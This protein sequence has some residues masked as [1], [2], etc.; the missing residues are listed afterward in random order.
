[1]IFLATFPINAL[2]PNFM[3]ILLVT[4]E[5]FYADGQTDIKKLIAVFCNFAKAPNKYIFEDDKLSSFRVAK[6]HFYP[7]HAPVYE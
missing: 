3:K 4:A 6:S 2:I 1:M 7:T 5:F